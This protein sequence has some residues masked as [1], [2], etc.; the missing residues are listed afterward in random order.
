MSD[1]V[2]RIML[3]DDSEA[4]NYFHKLVIEESGIEVEVEDCL[5]AVEALRRLEM[6]MRGERPL[7]DL[8]FLDINMPAVDGWEFLNRYAEIVPVDA[9]IPVVVM[10]STSMNPADRTKAE[11]LP[12]VSGYCTKPLTDEGIAKIVAEHL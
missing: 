9:L 8:I 6:A 1:N 2:K 11:S 7:P 10:L 5:E 12:V 4:D 3:V